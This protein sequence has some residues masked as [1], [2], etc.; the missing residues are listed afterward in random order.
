M[1]W[2]KTRKPIRAYEDLSPEEQAEVDAAGLEEVK[3]IFGIK[4]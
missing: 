4:V 2:T 3:S 1:P